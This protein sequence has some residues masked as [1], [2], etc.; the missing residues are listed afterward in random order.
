MTLNRD[1]DWFLSEDFLRLKKGD[2]SRVPEKAPT[3]QDKKEMPPPRSATNNLLYDY[4]IQKTLISRPF[5]FPLS[6]RGGGNSFL[7]SN[8]PC[9]MEDNALRK[10]NPYWNPGMGLW[11]C[12]NWKQKGDRFDM[13]DSVC[14]GLKDGQ[15]LDK[16][17]KKH[18]R[19][20][21]Q[22]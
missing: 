3:E 7:S 6:I 12:E 9:G 5:S 15:K 18:T 8:E 14:R 20:E 21:D 1:F 13:H 4:I 16:E 19:K 11:G 10:H 2:T 22:I 17:N